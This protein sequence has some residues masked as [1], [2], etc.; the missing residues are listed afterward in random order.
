[1]K[2][3]LLSIWSADRIE[4]YRKHEAAHLLLFSRTVPHRPHH[5][6][7][8]FTPSSSTNRWAIPL[9][10][11]RIHSRG[12]GIVLFVFGC[13]MRFSTAEQLEGQA[14]RNLQTRYK[15]GVFRP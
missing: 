4:R 8:V 5:A 9:R 10:V 2:V 1:M 12:R 6:V 11:D 3:Y 7:P 14:T 15:N 13:D